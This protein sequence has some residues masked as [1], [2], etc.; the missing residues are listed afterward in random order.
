MIHQQHIRNMKCSLLLL[1]L[2][3]LMALAHGKG[4][5]VEKKITKQFAITSNG[6]FTVDNKYGD[7]DI[8]IG[9]SNSIKVDV[10]IVV[11]AG[12]VKKAQEG[13]ERIT[14]T[15]NEGMNRVDARTEIESSSS[16]LSW[17]N[18]DN[19]EM[20]I[21][22]QVLVPADIYLELRNRYGDIY[23]ERTDRDINVDIAYGD[24]RLGDINAKL[25]LDMAYSEG[26]TSQISQGD[27]NLSYSDLEME[28]SHLLDVD[29]KYTDLVMGSVNRLDLVSAFSDI[30]G[31][32]VDE[33]TYSGKYDDLQLD[34]AK[35]VN[36][37][38][39]Y[40]E[41][42][43][44]G[45]DQNGEFD[46][47]YGVLI[48][49]NIGRDFSKLNINTSYTHVALSF[50]PGASFSLDADVSYCD[51]QHEGLKVTED[52]ERTT[53]RTLKGSR[54]SGGGLVYARM[55]YGELIIDK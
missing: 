12:N 31:Q 36:A 54:G 45:L 42:H 46:M 15:F 34:R 40:S 25:K 21:N 3:P 53:S 10:T 24:I 27:L 39:G 17:F 29:M 28:N 48:I 23:L 16:W 26:S 7:V 20:E 2:L 32:D 14:V 49:E 8:A 37:E 6:R 22:Y 35:K 47:R 43:L 33:V 4:E 9:V 18:S 38:S 1:C 30:Q 50:T 51:I 44:Q 5:R 11:E 41:I 19:V 55:S 52:I 13:L